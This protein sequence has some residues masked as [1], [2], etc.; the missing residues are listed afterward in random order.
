MSAPR[1]TRPAEEISLRIA[2]LVTVPLYALAFL[3]FSLLPARAPVERGERGGVLQVVLGKGAAGEAAPEIAAPSR[4][5]EKGAGRSRGRLGAPAT[6][7]PAARSGLAVSEG[8]AEQAGAAAGD[9]SAGNR[10]LPS[11]RDPALREVAR[12]R[13]GQ[14]RGG[15]NA[16][17]DRDAPARRPAAGE[18]GAPAGDAA[19]A[20]SG[21]DTMGG[22]A[23]GVGGGAAKPGDVAKGSDRGA[24][25]PGDGESG[26]RSGGGADSARESGRGGS[27]V[28]A[29]L[30]IIRQRIEQ[31]RSYPPAAR[32][33][34]IEGTVTASITVDR[35]G[36]LFAE[37]ILHSSGSAILDRAGLALLRRVF[38]VP[39]DTGSGFSL[40]VRIAYRL[41]AR[42]E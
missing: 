40:E 26:L 19:T 32:L 18:T 20:P 34:G 3:G 33:R 15:A 35:D 29:V 22:P 14:D 17:G 1:R 31:E 23:V 39:N 41:L 30:A 4:N 12:G 25:K 5:G 36:G 37:R 42:A 9:Q 24:A 21:A 11:V 27:G 2:I 10:V 16:S 13:V 38:P 8:D 7:A 6:A 28:P